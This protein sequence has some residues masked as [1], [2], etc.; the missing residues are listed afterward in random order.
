MESK[1]SF[2]KQSNSVA[3]ERNQFESVSLEMS[4]GPEQLSRT[5]QPEFRKS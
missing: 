1:G 5:S 4:F 3:A 2:A